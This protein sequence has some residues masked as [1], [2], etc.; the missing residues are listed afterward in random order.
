[1]PNALLV[2]APEVFRDEE[3][4]EPKRVLES[5]GIDV[6]TAS[7]RPGE[8]VGKLGM[9]A[10]AGISLEDA[11]GQTWDAIAFVGGAGARVFFDDH[12]AHEIARAQLDRGG[13]LAAICIAPST[14]ANAG[15]LDGVRATAFETEED[16]LVAHGA[17]WDGGPVVVDGK[18]VTAS[19]PA[20]AEAFGIAIAQL[21]LAEAPC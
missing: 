18:V 9:M 15:L 4:A 5:R 17:I 16:N 14:L 13:V 2:I 10:E 20:A 3:Y 12:V 6:T 11:R 21:V 7:T 1:M 8:C 19:G